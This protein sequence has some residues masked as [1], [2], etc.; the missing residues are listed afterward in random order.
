[1]PYNKTFDGL[2]T[3]ARMEGMD[4]SERSSLPRYDRKKARTGPRSEATFVIISVTLRLRPKK[5]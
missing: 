1:M 4:S 2:N 3:F 5:P